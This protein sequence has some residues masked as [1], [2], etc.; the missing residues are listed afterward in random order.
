M[1]T[2]L[3]F[4]CKLLKAIYRTQYVTCQKSL[5]TN[6]INNNNLFKTGFLLDFV[7]IIT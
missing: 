5:I 4:F 1:L 3:Y 7:D 6:V 2:F